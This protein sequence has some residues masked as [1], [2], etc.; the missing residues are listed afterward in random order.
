[1][2]N[3]THYTNQHLFN[4]LKKSE[5]LLILVR[6]VRE[7][8]LKNLKKDPKCRSKIELIQKEVKI[9]YGGTEDEIRAGNERIMLYLKALVVRYLEYPYKELFSE[10]ICFVF[11]MVDHLYD[12]N[13]KAGKLD[14]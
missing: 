14:F 8:F 11:D 4:F 6:D 7:D 13:K 2:T 9:L 12:K 5:L 10:D 1:M 3:I